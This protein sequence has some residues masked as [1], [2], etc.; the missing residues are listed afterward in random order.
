MF[1]QTSKRRLQ[2][3]F[4]MGNV[5]L[6]T[7]FKNL[8]TVKFNAKYYTFLLKGVMLF[9]SILPAATCTQH[10][11]KS[12]LRK[13]AA[14]GPWK[15]CSRA[16]CG[17]QACSWTTLTSMTGLLN[18]R[19]SLV[20]RHVGSYQLCPTTR[21]IFR[22]STF[23]SPY[24]FSIYGDFSCVTTNAHLLGS[25]HNIRQILRNPRRSFTVLRLRKL[26]IMF[27][28]RQSFLNIWQF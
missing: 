7:T 21:H 26:D 24:A 18:V 28:Y 17:P 15:L 5:Y 2:K 19:F 3:I 13:V 25:L 20:V 6:L 27:N 4:S 23:I 11:I 9:Q 16:S 14:R 8:S 10:N 1:F 12:I 22:C